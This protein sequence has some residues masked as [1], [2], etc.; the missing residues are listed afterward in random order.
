MASWA[1]RRV[2]KAR[3]FCMPP[4][5]MRM[6]TMMR[7]TKN[8]QVAD[9]QRLSVRKP[10]L[11]MAL[12]SRRFSKQ[13]YVAQNITAPAMKNPVAPISRSTNESTTVRKMPSRAIQS[14]FAVHRASA[15]SEDMELAP[16]IVNVPSVRHII[17]PAV[18]KARSRARFQDEY[19]R[20]LR[21][22]ARIIARNDKL[23]RND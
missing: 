8:V 16:A 14:G 4:I 2:G 7:K 22:V 18:E 11:L 9:S 13:T 19:S 12:G 15:A 5:M 3:V 20:A 10:Q 21:R 1:S 6:P 17:P 23:G